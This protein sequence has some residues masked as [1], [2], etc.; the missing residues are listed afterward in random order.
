M[1]KKS[2]IFALENFEEHSVIERFSHQLNQI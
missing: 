2:K 1:V